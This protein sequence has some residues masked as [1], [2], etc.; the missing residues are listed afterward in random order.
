MMPA[1]AKK[2][3]NGLVEMNCETMA[4]A[5]KDTVLVRRRAAP[6]VAERSG[7]RATTFTCRG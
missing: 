2:L 6:M 7:A 3:V 5:V 4:M 1:L